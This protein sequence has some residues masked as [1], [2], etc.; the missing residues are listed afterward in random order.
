MTRNHPPR[1]SLWPLQA[2]FALGA[3]SA[4]PALAQSNDADRDYREAVAH[5]ESHPQPSTRYVVVDAARMRSVPRAEGGAVTSV[6]IGAEVKVQCAFGE[7]VRATSERPNPSVGWIRADLLGPRAPTAAS[8]EQ[9]YRRASG[10]ER[11]TIAE[12]AIALRPFARE[13]HQLLIDALQAD[14]D[15]AA[16]QAAT[17]RRERMT[18]PKVERPAGE[19]RLL[20]GVDG[21]YLTAIARIDGRGRYADAAAPDSTFAVWRGFNLYR[22]GVADGLIQII[23][24]GESAGLGME[25]HVRRPPATERDE[26]LSGLAS[27][28]TLGAGA[29]RI[30]PKVSADEHRAVERELRAVLTRQRMDRA[31]IDKALRPYDE[32]ERNG[33]RVH[34]IALAGEQRLLVATADAAVRP[35][36]A[37]QA[38]T[39]LDAVLLLEVSGKQ[40]RNVGE[41]ARETGGDVVETHSFHDAL[42]LDGDGQAELIFRLH[43]YEGSEYQIWSQQSGQWK[44]VYAGGYV[45][46]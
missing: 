46:V 44:P 1:P 31:A 39:S 21:G 10:A 28:E 34:A 29:A 19:P 41:I 17:T 8:L 45:G 3:L 26:R 18:A 33:L 30:E 37:D 20:F 16:V 14:G 36:R 2:A 23:D 4:L 35:K 15:T 11:R 25:A 9:D 38:D 22:N 32:K 12:R 5:C 27:N 24:R 7:W 42:D 40:Y 43:Q 6:P 13:S